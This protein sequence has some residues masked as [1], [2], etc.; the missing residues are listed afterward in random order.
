ML[1][2]EDHHLGP[3]QHT[4]VA[5]QS[6]LE[7]VLPDQSVAKRMERPDRGVRVAIRDELIDPNLHLRGGLFRERQTED[8][9]RPGA[10]GGDEPGDPPRDH[11]RLAGTGSGHD[12]QRPV[13][14]RDR[15]E[16]LRVQSTE[17]R[18]QACRRIPPESQRAVRDETIPDRDLLERDGFSPRPRPGHRF[19]DRNGIRGHVSIML[20]PRDTLPV[21]PRS[22]LDR[23]ANVSRQ[24]G[25][26]PSR[27]PVGAP[28]T[29]PLTVPPR[30]DL[31]QLPS[32]T[33]V[34]R[35]ANGGC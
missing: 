12:Q 15:P 20:G 13:A 4:D 25:M 33:R 27:V 31:R 26:G 14:V 11:L 5:R 18:V 30:N 6:E 10:A 23:E 9:R 21:R 16:L 2:K 19:V 29:P 17:E 35:S 28:R 8:L 24:P 22:T 7:R 1:A 3:G 32:R 34:S